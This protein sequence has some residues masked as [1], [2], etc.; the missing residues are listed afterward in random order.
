MLRKF[1]DWNIAI[2][3]KVERILPKKFGPNPSLKRHLTLA[4]AEKM[5]AAPS[6]II[7]D[8]GG[9]YVCPYAEMRQEALGTKFY[10]ADLSES[11][12]RKN[13][14]ADEKLACDATKNLPFQDESIDVFVTRTLF[15]HLPENEI[16]IQESHR[17]LRQNGYAVHI[18]PC[19][20]APFAILNQLLPDALGKFL[21]NAF[22]PKWQGEVGFKAYYK[23]CYF[24]KIENLL[25]EYDFEIES[26]RLEN[27]PYLEAIF[28]ANVFA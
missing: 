6:Q 16:L 11:Q 21:L 10:M 18:F 19:K 15:E 13:K 17:V 8:V 4:V 9:G 1:I 26:K 2:S 14:A 25:N 5:N 12:L 27:P 23:N 22:F 24:P 3:D 28:S 20:F 7:L